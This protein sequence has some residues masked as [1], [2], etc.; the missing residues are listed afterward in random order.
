MPRRPASADWPGT[1]ASA[2]ALLRAEYS[3]RLHAPA[4]VGGAPLRRR[5]AH[6]AALRSIPGSYARQLGVLCAAAPA[7]LRAAIKAAFGEVLSAEEAATMRGVADG[8][9]YAFE[10]TV[11]GAEGLV[12]RDMVILDSADGE[13]RRVLAYCR[14]VPTDR[15]GAAALRD[16]IEREA[17]EAG[18]E[19]VT[20]TFRKEAA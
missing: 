7:E 9:E 14:L 3:Y 2:L 11:A 18:A 12:P 17:Y 19:Q 15:E 10:V 5:A 1:P 13:G 8:T 6:A 16:A 4:R 20:V